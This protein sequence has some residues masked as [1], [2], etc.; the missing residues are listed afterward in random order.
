[1][2]SL[3]QNLD[4]MIWRHLSI[5]TC[6]HIRHIFRVVFFLQLLP[7][8]VPTSPWLP[9]EVFHLKTWIESL[10]K[11]IYNK[12]MSDILTVVLQKMVSYNSYAG[13]MSVPSSVLK[14]GYISYIPRIYVSTIFLYVHEKEIRNPIK[15]ICFYKTFKI[16]KQQT[17]QA[18]ITYIHHW[19][20]WPICLFVNSHI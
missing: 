1:M 5:Y 7:C 4:T 11:Q 10:T 9:C 19:N 8:R 15:R 20:G 16:R 17:R 14:H 13:F 3:T 18:G 6:Q 2:S 12:N